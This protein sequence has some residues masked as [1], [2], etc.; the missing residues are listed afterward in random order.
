MIAAVSPSPLENEPIAAAATARA[1]LSAAIA[2][3]PPALDQVDSGLPHA[4]AHTNASTRVRLGRIYS[5]VEEAAAIVAPHAACRRGCDS[6]CRMDVSITSL[7]ADRLAAASGRRIRRP[8][9]AASRAPARFAGV[10]CPFLQDGAC[11]VYEARPFACRSHFAFTAT[12]YWCAPERALT[13]EMPLLSLGGAKM[14]YQQ[15]AAALPSPGFAD[16]RDYF[17]EASS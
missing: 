15:L 5:V 10:P 11:S 7:E 8:P 17:P 14:A 1:N 9:P 6:C 16:I 2:A 13:V 12:S 4:L 3:I